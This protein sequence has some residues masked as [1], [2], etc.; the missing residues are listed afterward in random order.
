MGL[1]YPSALV[2]FALVPAL[3]IAYLVRERPLRVTVSSVLAFRA[4]RGL[5]GE[6]PW[7]RPQLDWLFLV[8]VLILSLAVLAMAQPYVVRRR[9]PIAVVLDN[10]AA[11]QARDGVGTIPVRG[12]ARAAGGDAVLGTCRCGNHRVS[13]RPA[14]ASGGRTVRGRRSGALGDRKGRADRRARPT[15]RRRQAADRAGL[16]PPLQRK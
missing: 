14:A 11:M 10:S 5:K 1:L 13:N 9:K 3:L 6:R 16:R 4:L 7:G 12:C 2:F 8:E 15:R